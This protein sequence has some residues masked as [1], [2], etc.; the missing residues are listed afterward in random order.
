[1]A[2]DQRPLAR[3]QSW[4][5]KIVPEGQATFGGVLYT[6]S[7]RN[8]R[9]ADVTLVISAPVLV[10]ILQRWGAHFEGP[11]PQLHLLTAVLLDCLLL[12]LTL[13]FAIVALV[14]HPCLCYRDPV[15]VELVLDQV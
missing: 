1:M 3:F 13:Q 10:C 15:A 5:D 12:V 8:T 4:D 11:A 7:N 2:A 6:F 14:E 9:E